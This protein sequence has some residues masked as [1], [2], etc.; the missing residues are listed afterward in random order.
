MT[1][2]FWEEKPLILRTDAGSVQTR[3]ALARLIR[4]ESGNPA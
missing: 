3:R 2:E 4:E 1:A